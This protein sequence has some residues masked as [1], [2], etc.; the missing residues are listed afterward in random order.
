MTNGA[1]ELSGQ[2]DLPEGTE[3]EVAIRILNNK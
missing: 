3:I 1:L 2:I